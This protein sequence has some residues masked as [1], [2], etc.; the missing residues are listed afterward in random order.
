MHVI[1]FW[2]ASV[3]WSP[4]LSPI[5]ELCCHWFFGFL[6]YYPMVVF[7]LLLLVCKLC[8]HWKVCAGGETQMLLS[9]YPPH[10]KSFELC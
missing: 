9:K 8:C 10:A 2:T 4:M 1:K 7:V 3:L 6:H 5:C